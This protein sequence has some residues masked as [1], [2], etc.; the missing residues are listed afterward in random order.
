MS[1]KKVDAPF[2]CISSEMSNRFILLLSFF[3]MFEQPGYGYQYH[4]SAVVNFNITAP[5]WSVA[6]VLVPFKKDNA[7]SPYMNGWTAFQLTQETFANVSIVYEQIDETIF[8]SAIGYENAT[9][10]N[11]LYCTINPPFCWQVYHNGVRKNGTG[12]EEMYLLPNDNI[13][14]AYEHF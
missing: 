4:S 6:N 5:R 9:G 2:T 7:S 14:W 3:F 11:P 1:K 13:L 10:E 12:I 8:V